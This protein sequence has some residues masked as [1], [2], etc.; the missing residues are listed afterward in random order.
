MK[1]N[2]L[3][4]LVIIKKFSDTQNLVTKTKTYQFGEEMK[5]LF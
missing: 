4:S 1:F 5:H 2:K 3:T